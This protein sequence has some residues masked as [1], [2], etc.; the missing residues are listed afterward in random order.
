MSAEVHTQA[1]TGIALS[2]S[3]TLSLG[4]TTSRIL[5]VSK[6]A[7]EL[8]LVLGEPGVDA[9]RQHLA[10]VSEGE[11]CFDVGF[12]LSGAGF[13]ILVTGQPGT[14]VQLVEVDQLDRPDLSARLAE[15]LATLVHGIS[16]VANDERELPFRETG[17]TWADGSRGDFRHTSGCLLVERQRRGGD[18][19]RSRASPAPVCSFGLARLDPRVQTSPSFPGS[20]Y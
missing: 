10:T 6:G 1:S 12:N 7:L 13:T 8:F 3:R 16:R 2:G 9:R 20:G 5:Q 4:E 18:L 19:S 15:W 17:S 14:V 11:W